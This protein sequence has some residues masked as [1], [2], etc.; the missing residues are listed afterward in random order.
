MISREKWSPYRPLLCGR[1]TRKRERRPG[2]GVAGQTQELPVR[3]WDGLVSG[4]VGIPQLS[5][6]RLKTQGRAEVRRP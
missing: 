5:L 6:V 4:A 2:G 3:V 1:S